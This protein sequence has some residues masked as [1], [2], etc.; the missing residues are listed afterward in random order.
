MQGLR[1]SL[2]AVILGTFMASLGLAQFDVGR[3]TGTIYDQS[4]GVVPNATVTIKNI[5]TG[6][7]QK[8]TGGAAGGFTSA[9]LPP[10]QYVVTA[11]ASGKTM[12]W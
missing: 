12:W 10:G 6:F 2:L 9:A 5:G 8:L 1:R 11:T 3:I 7:E 4:G